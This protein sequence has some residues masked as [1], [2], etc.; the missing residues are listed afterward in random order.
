MVLVERIDE[1]GC[2][3]NMDTVLSIR[4]MTFRARTPQETVQAEKSQLKL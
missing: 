2:N 4:G 1:L 3:A